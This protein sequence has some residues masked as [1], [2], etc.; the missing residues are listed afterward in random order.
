MPEEKE[1][2]HTFMCVICTQLRVNNFIMSLVKR[3][4]VITRHPLFTCT[5]QWGSSFTSSQ[6]IKKSF[7][8]RESWPVDPRFVQNYGI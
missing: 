2:Y 8:K 5:A 4:I 7:L 1:E 6:S 3:S